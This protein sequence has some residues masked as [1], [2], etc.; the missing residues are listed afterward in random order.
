MLADADGQT[1]LELVM[2]AKRALIDSGLLAKEFST[3]EAILERREN[4]LRCT[5]GS[6]KLDSFFK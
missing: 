5:T 4:L 6:S 2:K 1:A 3:A